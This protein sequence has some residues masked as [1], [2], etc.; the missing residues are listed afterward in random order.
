MIAELLSYSFMQKAMVAG[1]LVSL[2]C[3]VIS[4]FVVLKKVS[5]MGAGISHAAFGG[6][7][8]GVFADVNP[9]IMAAI[10]TITVAW[11][12][13][14]LSRKGKLP[15]ETLI[16]IFFATSMALGI[17]L[18]GLSKKY[19]V[20]LFGYL[21]GNILAI[22]REELIIMAVMTVVVLF[23]LVAILKELLFITF[24]EELAKV[25]GIST[26]FVN[27]VFMLSMA[28]TIVVSMKVVGIILVSA[29]LVIPGATAH[30]LTRNFYAMLLI[31]V[32][33]GVVSTF[34]GLF[35]SYAFDLAPGGA[36]VIVAACIFAVAFLLRRG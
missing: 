14:M 10:Y 21:F 17:L 24:N 33:V 12:I 36:I 15:E 22:S 35:I 25:S 3:G 32:T 20:D 7:A 31:S 1:I 34:L 19:N 30:L 9:L 5:F 4:V 27:S 23:Q 18:I 2:L 8:L 26:N 28:V 13:E 11:A 6:I 16:G 29:L